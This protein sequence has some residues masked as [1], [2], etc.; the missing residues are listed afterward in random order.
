MIR[1]LVTGSKGQLG[2]CIQKIAEKYRKLQFH[3]LDAHHLDITDP[4]KVNSVFAAGGYQFCINCAAYTN[5]EQAE[6]TPEIAF[7]VNAEGVRYLA[8][9]SRSHEVTLIHI[10]TDYVF[11][12]EKNTPYVTTDEPNPINEYGRSKLAG[13]QHVRNTLDA[14]YIIRTSWL[15]SEFG[16]N[17]YNTILDKARKGDTLSVTNAQLGCPTNANSLANYILEN[18]LSGRKDYGIN[19]FTDGKAMTWFQFA[20]SILKE[21]GLEDEVRLVKDTNYRTFAA[22]PRNSVLK[23]EDS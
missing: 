8:L 10:S 9:A 12:G 21:N 3:F 7:Q 2:K 22:R 20:Q 15:Y 23:Q 16:N 11:D 17:F 4:E 6:K 13:E 1:V 14:Y 18:I 19:H 5:V